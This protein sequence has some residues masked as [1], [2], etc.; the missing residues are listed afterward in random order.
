MTHSI[1]GRTKPP[2]GWGTRGV[3]G[4]P[5]QRCLGRLGALR[6]GARQGCESLLG[7]QSSLCS[8]PVPWGSP[9]PVLVWSS[10]RSLSC[11]GGPSG[12]LRW[13]RPGALGRRIK[14]GRTLG[15][16]IEA[17]RSR[18]GEQAA[19]HAWGRRVGM[20]CAVRVY[21]CTEKSMGMSVHAC[22]CRCGHVCVHEHVYVRV[23]DHAGVGVCRVVGGTCPT[24]LPW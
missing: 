10:S 4:G 9:K 1:L 11:P 24:L 21:M 12:S 14:A 16:R 7:C 3:G 23:C 15:R 6:G 5:G 19:V 22:E 18:H 20:S 13:A 2:R 8:C 17:G